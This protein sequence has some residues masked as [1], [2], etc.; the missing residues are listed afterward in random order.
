MIKSDKKF[1]A[2]NSENIAKLNAY[3]DANKD[4]LYLII[5][6]PEMF[7]WLKIIENGI[8][9]DNVIMIIYRGIRVL[10]NPYNSTKRLTFVK[11]SSDYIDFNLPCVCGIYPD[12]KH[13]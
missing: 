2:K 5:T 6:S 1:L 9:T 12:E 8:M 7:E 11:K 10:N 4:D 3:I 13:P